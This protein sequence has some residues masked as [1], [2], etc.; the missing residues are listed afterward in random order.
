MSPSSSRIQSIFISWF[1]SCLTALGSYRSYSIQ[2]HVEFVCIIVVVGLCSLAAFYP[3][4]LFSST[5]WIC[6]IW[7][8]GLF[9]YVHICVYSMLLLYGVLLSLSITDSSFLKLLCLELL[10]FSSP[11]NFFVI[12][13]VLISRIRI[14]E[15]VLRTTF[16]STNAKQCHI[17]K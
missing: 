15:C 14:F 11:P 7:E 4:A 16:R 3:Y 5:V 8:R 13:L 6:V 10:F 9:I 17:F 12:S 2:M 1:G